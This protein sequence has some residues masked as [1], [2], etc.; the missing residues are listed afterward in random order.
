MASYLT[1]MD[2]IHR[3]IFEAPDIVAMI[4]GKVLRKIRYNLLAVNRSQKM[5]KQHVAANKK[6][7]L[8]LQEHQDNGCQLKDNAS[9]RFLYSKINRLS[10]GP[11]MKGMRC[12]VQSLQAPNMDQ[13]LIFWLIVTL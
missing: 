1:D 2:E 4:R 11:L 8:A 10:G 6:H 7:N 5:P 12:S 9:D 13:H 3:I